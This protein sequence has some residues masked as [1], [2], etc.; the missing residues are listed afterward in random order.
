MI[1]GPEFSH[2]INRIQPV[3]NNTS[4]DE[5]NDKNKKRRVQYHGRS[6][7]EKDE[8]LPVQPKA[9]TIPAQPRNKRATGRVYPDQLLLE[10][11]QRMFDR[12]VTLEEKV[13]Q[14]CFLETKAIYDTSLQHDVEMLIQTWQIGGILFKEDEYKTF[15]EGHYKRQAYLIE[16][17]QEVSKIPLLMA[18]DFLHG[19][20]LYL[21][22]DSLPQQ[23]LSEQLCSDLGKAVMDQNR[24]LGIHIQFDRER[25]SNKLPLTEK[26]VK[27]FRKGIRDTYGVVG[28]EKSRKKEENNWLTIKTR[29]PFTPL[30]SLRPLSSQHVEEIVGLKTLGFF[31]ATRISDPLEKVVLSAFQHQNDVLLLAIKNLSESI[32]TICKL[33]RSGKIRESELDRHVLKILIIKAHLFKDSKSNP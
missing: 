3:D 26:Q 5:G 29:L 16:R 14:L 24:L 28:K 20:S 9:S 22:G 10:Q 25:S 4:E 1:Y 18:N 8:D 6:W 19:L 13:A 23:P 2:H 21:Q 7:V 31:D 32:R 12:L 30:T 15:K 33:I 11:A 27:M 17:Y